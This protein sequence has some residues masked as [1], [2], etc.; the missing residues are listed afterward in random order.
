MKQLLTIVVPR[1]ATEWYKVAYCLEFSI[2]KVIIIR[3]QYKNDPEKCCY[4]LLKRWISN[5]GVSPK[6]WSTLLSALEQFVDF[7]SA[8]EE[9]E[10]EV[11]L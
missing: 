2:S 7:T 8:Q 3:Q 4:H 1:I 11:K 5:E 10:M 9:I 6:N